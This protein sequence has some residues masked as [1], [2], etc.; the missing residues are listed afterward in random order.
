MITLTLNN[1]YQFI[2]KT[3]DVRC[4]DN[5]YYTV[6]LYAKTEGYA[7][8]GRHLVSVKMRLA[9]YKNST[10]YG[11]YTD[12][13]VK[14]GT[15]SAISWDGQQIPNRAWNASSITEGGVTYPRW[16]DLKEGTAVVDVG[17]GVARDVAITASWQRN[18]ISGTPPT[19]LPYSNTIS[20][21]ITVTLP[22]IAGASTIT[23]ASNVTLGDNC[24]VTWT[25]QAESLRYKLKFSIGN[26][27]Y[28]TDLLHPNKTTAYTYAGYTFLVDEVAKY[29]PKKTGTMTATLYTYSMNTSA[30][31]L[32]ESLIG[33]DNETFTVTVP[34]NEA[35]KPTISMAISPGID[36][37]ASVGDIYI[38]SK[39]KVIGELEASLKY[40]AEIKELSLIVE[41]TAYSDPFVSDILKGS[42]KLLV[43]G[44]V[45][46]S[47]DHYATVNEEITVIP[48]SKP[49]LQAASGESNIVAARCDENGNLNDTGTGLKI[50]AK[51]AYEK[52]IANGEQ[53]NYGKIQYR[54]RVEGGAWPDN[55]VTIL[56][57]SSSTATEVNTKVSATLDIT[58]NYQVQVR[59]VDNIEEPEPITLSVPSEKVYM[60][61]PPFGRGMGLGGYTE[62]DPD[63]VGNLDIHWKTRLRGGLYLLK[64]G[65]WITDKSLPLPRGAVTEGWNPNNIASGVYE[66][67]EYPLTTYQGEVVMETG[68]LVQMS[69]DA[70]D[71]VLIQLAFP[72]DGNIPAYRI[73]MSG[74]WTDWIHL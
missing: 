37:S 28:T 20:A 19:W 21:N 45:K 43:T 8:T 53:N 15:A 11:Y 60:H 52:V 7:A 66:V 4:A 44:F 38:Q 46:D 13:S 56:D 16:I 10:F 54:Y 31:T 59:A 62:G 50:K 17:Y 14:V 73:R 69:V 3:D 42:G 71:D 23:S 6:L 55:W 24:S 51:I 57:T 48:Y 25:P 41:G 64:D 65:K 27:S 26:W 34:E 68:V 72:I 58:K 36:P 2:G 35:T 67:S 12:G 40:G 49:I 39:S 29:V 63:G 70:N 18:A 32:E 30:D 74:L 1:S 22:A 9:C 5:Y 61:R 47:R 33:S